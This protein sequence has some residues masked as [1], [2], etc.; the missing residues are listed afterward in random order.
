MALKTGDLINQ[1]YAVERPLG[2]GGMAEVW[3]AMDQTADREVAL[4][5]LRGDLADND[6]LVRLLRQEARTLEQLDHPC[7]VELLAVEEWDGRPVLVMEYVAGGAMADLAGKSP[8]DYLPALVG[9]AEAMAH[10]HAAG[11]VHRDLRPSNVLL[12]ERANP[13]VA[14]FGIASALAGIQAGPKS[15]GAL[16]WASP[17]QVQ[18]RA[19][20]PAD[21][22]YALGAMLYQLID[23]NPPFHPEISEARV[24][25]EMPRAPRGEA[26]QALIELC[27]TMLAKSAVDRPSS[28]RDVRRAL[29]EIMAAE[30]DMTPP[31]RVGEDE[32]VESIAPVELDFEPDI[33]ARP[34][35][36]KKGRPMG[37]ALGAL[38]LLIAL[39]LGVIFYLPKLVDER[40]AATPTVTGADPGTAAT[41]GE[42]AA[43]GQPT[44]QAGPSP[45]ELKLQF[46]QREAAEAILDR[47]VALQEQLEGQAVDRWGADEF[48]AATASVEAGD[49]HFR[50]QAYEDATAAYESG[51]A[52]L[53]ALAESAPEQVAIAVEQGNQA[54]TEGDAERAAQ[55]FELALAIDPQSEDAETGRERAGNIDRVIDLMN[56]GRTF[57][58]ANR[59]RD[60]R[61]SYASA[62]E[63]DPLYDKA[64]ESLSR[65]ASQLQGNAFAD[66]MSAGFAALDAGN[67]DQARR[68]FEK[69]AKLRPDSREP[70]DAL[71]QVDL[72]ATRTSIDGWRRRADKAIAEERWA[73]A[74][75]A[76]DRALTIDPTLVFAQNG[77]AEIAPRAELDRQLQSLLDEPSRLSDE[78]ALAAA[79][80]LLERAE[81][82]PD[83][84]RV[85]FQ[86]T[87]LAKQIA[88]YSKTVPVT[89][90]SDNICEVI[91]YKVGRLGA[92]E[93]RDFQLR[94]GSYTVVG[95][96]I[97][98]RDER[99]EFQ[100][101]TSGEP[102]TVEIRCENP[103]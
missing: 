36:E 15:R 72:A 44:Q 45:Y 47:F 100:V 42:P 27:M 14:D 30:A 31:P 81:T 13:K 43:A 3:L 35:R 40:V 68:G 26:P 102:T 50:E 57:E 96:R 65:V 63:L 98:Y 95:S 61:D 67:L 87:E 93:S 38:S 69:A 86:R 90:V 78:R 25:D 16:F 41:S 80:Q 24:V 58:A 82:A 79:R 29:V 17:Q 11:V 8:T 46:R 21:D 55:A 76:Y 92:F 60:A 64:R 88:A 51:V 48:A 4:K 89:L 39:L 19:P 73:D 59:L 22:I 103:I 66:A 70:R 9:V 1:R 5:V 34:R 6:G 20:S 49:Q 75:D 83:G 94:P 52:Q 32:P 10:A 101:P 7:I 53:T 97:G 2:R 54:L 12:D 91:L 56:E 62:A 84:P 28:M 23:G 18:G 37:W 74:L 99:K 33:I 77:K 85:R 71:A